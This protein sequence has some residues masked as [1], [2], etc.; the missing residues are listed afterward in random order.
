M[1]P[2]EYFWVTLIVLFALIG[3]GRG[4][5]KELGATTILLLSLFALYVGWGQLGGQ[6][7]RV[8]QGQMAGMPAE[9]VEASVQKHTP[10]TLQDGYGY[11]WW[12]DDA[13]YYMAL[14][15]A[16]QF[17][18]VIPEQ[19]MVVVFAS[20]LAERDFY[21]PQELLV[22]YILPSV[23]SAAPLP[24]NPDAVNRLREQTESLGSPG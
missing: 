19:D 16:G 15:Y 12:V 7:T 2:V 6:I 5:V 13:G 17:I 9:W 23:K 14:G 1:I 8:V 10:A 18:F 11:Q 3:M 22:N 4:M 21:T 20:E 24:E